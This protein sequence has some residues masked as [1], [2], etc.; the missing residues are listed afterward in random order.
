MILSTKVST[1]QLE[2]VI[3]KATGKAVSVNVEEDSDCSQTNRVDQLSE[4]V[5]KM[6]QDIKQHQMNEQLLTTSIE[7]LQK[8]TDAKLEDVNLTFQIFQ[9]RSEKQTLLN[10]KQI[11]DL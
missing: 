9:E 8:N 3:S 11:A 1:Q 10:Q 2:E 6:E 5:G 7:A 4:M